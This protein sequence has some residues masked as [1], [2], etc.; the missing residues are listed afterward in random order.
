VRARPLTADERAAV[1]AALV[2]ARQQRPYYARAL[3]ALTPMA[4]D[5]PTVGVDRHWRLYVNLDWLASLP[6][7]QQGAALAQHEVEHLLR[8]HDRRAREAHTDPIAWNV[9]ADA[10]INDDADAGALPPDAIY[11]RSLGQPDGLLAEDYLDH[12]KIGRCCGGGSGAGRQL[13]GEADVGDAPGVLGDEA[14]TLRD[15]VAD[16]VRAHVRAHGRGSVPRGVEIWAE[17][18]ARVVPVPWHRRVSAIVHR[19][20]RDIERGRLDWSWRRLS[21]RQGPVLRPGMYAPKP[22]V[23][24][25]VDT[26][27]SMC[28]MGD[29]VVSLVRSACRAHLV[30]V[31]QID[32]AIT[33]KGSRKPKVFV[34]GGGTDLRPAIEDAALHSDLVVAIT[35]CDT[36]WPESCT[37][38][39]V[40]VTWPGCSAS[41]SWAE[42]VEVSRG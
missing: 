9:A 37:R 16:D 33:V 27:G 31:W 14:E 29:E 11:P 34:G 40:V 17:A 7:G 2:A 19:A 5:V 20:A 30:R 39:L 15:A 26:S 18:R 4:A 8:D 12:V 42:R 28:A 22:C 24:L 32:A 3:S 38:R 13:A 6:I 36:P 41:P 21:R 23:G 25:V 35:D 1:E 10:E